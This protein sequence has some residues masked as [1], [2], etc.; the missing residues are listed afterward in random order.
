MGVFLRPRLLLLLLVLLLGAGG[1]LGATPAPL[2]TLASADTGDW[3]ADP[4]LSSSSSSASSPWTGPARTSIFG[5]DYPI[6]PRL[7]ADA[8]HRHGPSRWRRLNATVD[9]TDNEGLQ[10]HR[11]AK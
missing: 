1:W 10:I 4:S 8:E 6:Y 3:F 11:G 7:G 5:A 2:P 9:Q